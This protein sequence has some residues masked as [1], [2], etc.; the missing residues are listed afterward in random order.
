MRQDSRTADGASKTE[1]Y[2]H[3]HMKSTRTTSDEA[4]AFDANKKRIK[5][6]TSFMMMRF[7]C[8]ERFSD[9]VDETIL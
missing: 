8:E 1:S 5:L 9:L 3:R 6:T 2:R 4:N 7:D